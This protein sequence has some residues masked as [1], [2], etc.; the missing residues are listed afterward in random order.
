MS[1]VYEGLASERTI[2]DIQVPVK[3]GSGL[4]VVEVAA[5]SIRLR[6]AKQ[7]RRITPEIGKDPEIEWS[8]NNRSGDDREREEA[9]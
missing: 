8:N 6:C 2:G 7:R 1:E 3:H 9:R 5:I 4:K